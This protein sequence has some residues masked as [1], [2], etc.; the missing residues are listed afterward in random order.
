MHGWVRGPEDR[1]FSGSV[2]SQRGGQLRT[3]GSYGDDKLLHLQLQLQNGV[4]GEVSCV[5]PDRCTA[6]GQ[7][8]GRLADHAALLT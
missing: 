3:S 8:L 6:T 7:Q 5:S 1:S 2:M 4:L